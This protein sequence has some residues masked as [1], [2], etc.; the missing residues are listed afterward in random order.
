[1][2]E[3]VVGKVDVLA[4][5][6]GGILVKPNQNR[7]VALWSCTATAEIEISLRQNRQFRGIGKKAEAN[8]FEKAFG[9]NYANYINRCPLRSN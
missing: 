3:V 6:S 1:V 8:A 9:F 4:G 7:H 5:G 2:A